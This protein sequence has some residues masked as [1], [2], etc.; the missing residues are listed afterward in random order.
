[1]CSLSEACGSVLGLGGSGRRL[2]KY[3]LRRFSASFFLKL[4]ALAFGALRTAS[5]DIFC[6]NGDVLI[7]L[8]SY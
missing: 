8:P 7:T 5:G 1:M 4:E 2:G 3:F 6:H